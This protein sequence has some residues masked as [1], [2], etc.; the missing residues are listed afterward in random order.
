MK[1]L[2]SFSSSLNNSLVCDIC[3]DGIASID[4]AEIV[5]ANMA[6]SMSIKH[7]LPLFVSVVQTEDGS[8]ISNPIA[9]Y[10]MA[11]VTQCDVWAFGRKEVKPT[12]ANF[13]NTDIAF[14]CR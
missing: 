2:I 7:G 4:H 6:G 9:D 13:E 11:G 10:F 12:S 3:L 14:L 8:F 5:A 1:A